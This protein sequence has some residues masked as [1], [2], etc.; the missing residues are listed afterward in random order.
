MKDHELDQE[1]ARAKARIDKLKYLIRLR[2]QADS[3][4]RRHLLTNG[5][6]SR[7]F[8]RVAQIVT[9]YFDVPFESV[10]NT[11][12]QEK[13]VVPRHLIIHL[14]REITKASFQAIGDLIQKD[15]SMTHFACRRIEERM[16]VDPKFAAE[17][18]SLRKACEKSP[19]DLVKNTPNR[20]ATLGNGH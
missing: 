17:V 9:N 5:A 20:M 14:V 16:S 3:L 18:D 19:D 7:E 6:L 12:R 13:Y 11:G 15:H 1:I 8:N 10:I 4:E 2:R